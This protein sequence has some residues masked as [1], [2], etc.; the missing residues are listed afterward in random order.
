[1]LVDR[2]PLGASFP[3]ASLR[4]Y[5]KE[6]YFDV[7]G[8]T[9]STALSPGAQLGAYAV[10]ESPGTHPFGHSFCDGPVVSRLGV[11]PG[12]CRKSHACVPVGSN[13]LRVNSE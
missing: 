1:M 11:L 2:R 10:T 13:G 8:P 6:P 4:R 12:G 3:T 9:H 7:I 5:G